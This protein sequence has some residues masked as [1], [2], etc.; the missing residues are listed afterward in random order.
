[1]LAIERQICVRF[2]LM[3][4]PSNV[5]PNYLSARWD[6]TYAIVSFTAGHDT[7]DVPSDERSGLP[8]TVKSTEL[9]PVSRRKAS[10]LYGGS[11]LRYHGY[12][13]FS[14]TPHYLHARENVRVST[15]AEVDS[16]L[17]TDGRPTVTSFNCDFSPDSLN[18]RVRDMAMVPATVAR[19][20]FKS[21]NVPLF[22]NYELP[23]AEM[24]RK[25]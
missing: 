5:F 19:L 9:T 3:L 17:C 11:G 25:T 18:S 15:T 1:M 6:Y 21:S 14:R 2:A 7:L 8:A 12:S 10:P 23:R 20:S 22:F 13:M 4:V 24:R 16:Q